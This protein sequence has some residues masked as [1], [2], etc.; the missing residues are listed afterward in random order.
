[1]EGSSMATPMVTGVAALLLSY[2]PSLTP[3]EIKE[4]LLKPSFKPNQIVNKPQ[5]TVQVSFNS[6]S[7]SGGIVN[8][9]NAVKMAITMKKNKQ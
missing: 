9:C 7:V 5:T 6:L 3:K 4:I 1:M 8:A 2:F